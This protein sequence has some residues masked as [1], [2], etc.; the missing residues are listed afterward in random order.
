M[1]LCRGKGDFSPPAS[2]E[3][4]ALW[5]VDLNQSRELIVIAGMGG[6]GCIPKPLVYQ[7]IMAW[8]VM[9]RNTPSPW[10]VSA[11]R[12]MDEAWRRE[13]DRKSGT[14]SKPVTDGPQHQGLGDYCQGDKVD[15]CR[16]QFG[17]QLEKVCA[18][19]PN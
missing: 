17:D 19:C 6:G 9:T 8:A 18:T 12:A 3:Y 2:A 7:E 16:K 15:E 11:L 1:Q 10:E 4:L 14:G 5:F 13:Y